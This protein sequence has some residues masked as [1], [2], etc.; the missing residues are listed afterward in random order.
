M[1][2]DEADGC[3][4]RVHSTNFIIYNPE[5][6]PFNCNDAVQVGP[7]QAKAI[8]GRILK[9]N[10]FRDSLLLTPCAKSGKTRHFALEHPLDL[11]L[12]RQ[13]SND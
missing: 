5:Y 10:D 6:H 8:R 13:K 12:S 4:R 11:I 9:I 7:Q 3:S 2:N 1:K